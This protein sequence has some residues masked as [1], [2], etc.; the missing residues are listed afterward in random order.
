M[1]TYIF[2]SGK[3]WVLSLAELIA[4]FQ[5]R[6]IQFKIDYFSTE[7]F[8]LSFET[9]LDPQIIDDLG[10]TI[11]IAQVKTTLP[12]KTL[13]E[14]FI[15]KNKPAQ[16]QTTQTIAASSALEGMSKAPDKL[17]FGISIYTSDNAIKPLGGRIQRFIGSAIKGKLMA[18]GKK[19]NF[20]G[21]GQD[22][23]EA[24]LSHIEVLKK[25][26]IE[27]QAEV[28]L[29]IGKNQTWIANTVAVHNPFEFQKR[30][31][32]KPNQRAIFGM[33]PRLA[34]M[35]V[36]LSACTQGKT[37]L[38]AF[39]GV[40][41]ILQEALLEHTTV[42]GM[43]VNSWCVK[44]S[45]ENLEWLTE[46]YGISGADFRVLQG[47]VE[48]LAEKVG[49]ESVD[50]VVSEPDLG[51]AIR[52]T[53]TGAYAQRIIE[54]LEPLFLGFIEEAYRALRPS[55]RLVVVTPFI[56]TRSREAITMPID[57]KLREIGFKRVYVF[58]DELFGSDAPEH[59]RLMGMASLVEIDERHKIGREIHILQ[60]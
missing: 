8:T 30:D 14:A 52:E 6:N 35:M 16:K 1:P 3:N 2:I 59:D 24:Q 21:T 44:A 48:R 37:L 41:T 33:P 11:K 32:Y 46:E 36:N 51:P 60:K 17:L 4:Y 54:K 31:V 57:E 12:S 56:R 18:Q 26:L 28:L 47:D 15:E 20:M 43:D 49:V 34:R 5:A 10:G 7:F 38:D 39:C 13:K 45:E 58:T 53:P 55:G 27:N 29:C 22:R 19:S 40:G 25:N 42:V 9:Y 23:S 50:C